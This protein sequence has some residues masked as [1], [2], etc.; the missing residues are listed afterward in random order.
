M[1]IEQNDP[2]LFWNTIKKMNNW[3]KKQL[4]P[5]EDIAPKTWIDYYEKLLNDTRPS[6]PDTSTNI[7]TFQPF[8]DRKITIEELHSALR[9]LKNNKAPGPDG[10]L[11]E[12]LKCFGDKYENTLLKLINLIFTTNNCSKKVV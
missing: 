5:V 1:K 11:G 7:P 9:K 3:G 12:Y 2:K 10:I 6:T 4:D 8:L